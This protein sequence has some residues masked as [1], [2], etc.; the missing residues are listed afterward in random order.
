LACAWLI[1]RF[2][3]PIAEIRYA[4]PPE[5]GEVGFDM[6][7]GMFG[8]H[9]NYC[10]FETMIAAFNLKEPGLQEIAEIVHEIDLRD[11]RY[12]RPEAA[13]I[14]LILKGWLREGTSDAKLSVKASPYL[15][16]CFRP[17]PAMVDLPKLDS[18]G[19]RPV[20]RCRPIAL[21]LPLYRAMRSLSEWYDQGLISDADS[22]TSLTGP[23][24]S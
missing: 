13:G 5:P 20:Y 16:N 17:C 2:I 3:N 6:R 21:Q 24:A 4:T 19:F 9:G 12:H 15:K 18:Y 1:R 8:H 10:T 14:A 11:G 22:K 23:A 7:E